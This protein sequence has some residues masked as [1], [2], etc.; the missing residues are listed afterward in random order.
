M[1]T[2]QPFLCGIYFSHYPEDLT[3]PDPFASREFYELCQQ[4]RHAKSNDDTVAAFEA[5]KDF[6]R[7]AARRAMLDSRNLLEAAVRSAID[8][9]G[10]IPAWMMNAKG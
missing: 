4:Y 6:G 8:D 1:K 7:S 9:T 5:L 3:E 2:L 10:P